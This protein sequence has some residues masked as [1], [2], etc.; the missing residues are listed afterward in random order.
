MS[1]HRIKNRLPSIK[2]KN[3]L[4]NGYWFLNANGDEVTV[5]ATKEGWCMVKELGKKK[6]YV[7][8]KEFIM[9]IKNESDEQ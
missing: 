6:P 3:I 2:T 5:L 1:I 9:A 8:S 4:P 7:L